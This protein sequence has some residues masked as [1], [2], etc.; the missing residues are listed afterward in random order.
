MTIASTTCGGSFIEVRDEGTAVGRGRY[1]L[2]VDGYVKTSS[3]SLS[4][5]M[6]EFNKYN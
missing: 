4:D 6:Y 1:V 3:D 5:I 2:Y